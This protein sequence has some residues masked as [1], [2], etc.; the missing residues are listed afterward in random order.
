[1]LV[2]SRLY[3]EENI[4]LGPLLPGEHTFRDAESLCP[5]D[6]LVKF[7]SNQQTSCSPS[8]EAMMPPGQCDSRDP[9]R[10]ESQRHTIPVP[11]E[12]HLLCPYIL[13]FSQVSQSGLLEE[14][15]PMGVF[16]FFGFC[17]FVLIFFFTKTL[18]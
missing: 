10:K 17:F 12:G 13:A 8:L 15:E 9:D 7:L 6:K 4:S 18:F 1:M 2:P 5:A 3:T 11:T 16:L 14:I